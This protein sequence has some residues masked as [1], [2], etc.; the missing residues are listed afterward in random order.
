VAARAV[1]YANT[2]WLL[3]FAQQVVL[4]LV[5]VALGHESLSGLFRLSEGEAA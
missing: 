2:L 3:Q 5:Y 4:G 1:A